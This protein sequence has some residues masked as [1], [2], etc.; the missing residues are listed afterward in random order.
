MSLKSIAC[1]CGKKLLLTQNL[2]CTY[3][4]LKFSLPSHFLYLFSIFIFPCIC[5]DGA[6]SRN[7]LADHRDAAI[8]NCGCTQAQYSP[9]IGEK[10]VTWQNNT[11]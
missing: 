7:N 11:Q 2:L 1:G 9:S 3:A 4:M 8:R 5:F 10:K 6:D